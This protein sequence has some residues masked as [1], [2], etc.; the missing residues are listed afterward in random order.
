MIRRPP[1]STQG[2]SSA[3]SDVYKRQLRARLGAMS[4]RMAG[5]RINVVTEL[6]TATWSA[7]Q[8]GISLDTQA[9]YDAVM[10]SGGSGSFQRPIDW[11]SS[12]ASNVK[13]PAAFSVNRQAF[14]ATLGSTAGFQ[15][16]PVE[17]SIRVNGGQLELVPGKPGKRIDLDNAFSEIS[18]SLQY[19]SLIH[20]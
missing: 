20:I 6:G 9:T 19:L 4:N 2:V 17:P 13:V 15:R 11:L 3:A 8:L 14:E 7:S 16:A 10:A 12:L 18:R 1:R 5:T